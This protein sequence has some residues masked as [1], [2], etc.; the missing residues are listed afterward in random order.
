MSALR[1][2]IESL[3]RKG[4]SDSDIALCCGVS[5][6]KVQS[7]KRQIKADAAEAKRNIG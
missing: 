5:W 4:L 1:T 7:I 3:M 2:K 6:Q